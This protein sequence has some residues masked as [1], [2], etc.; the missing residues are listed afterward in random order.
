MLKCPVCQHALKACGHQL[1]CEHHHTYDQAKTGYYNLANKQG[2][3]NKEMVKARVAFLKKGYY[4]FL[5]QALMEQ[6]EG[7]WLDVGCGPGYYTKD[8]GIDLSKAAIQ[9]A[10][11]HHPGHF[12]V[13]NLA[14][15]PFMDE[16]FDGVLQVF[17]PF[18]A[19][20]SRRVLKPGGHLL[21]VGPAPRHL[22]EL[23]ERLYE[24]PYL[25]PVKHRQPEGF[26][27]VDEQLLEQRAWV[28]D[29]Q[30]LVGMTPYAYK[31]SLDALA[32]LA[33]CEKFECTFSFQL[34]RWE[35]L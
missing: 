17:V 27:L 30:E 15:L 35:K 13:G 25:N 20:E 8:W 3:D 21:V 28:E 7:L 6:M 4:R 33:D 9:Q 14:H 31:T 10:S 19:K 23:K 5:K 16:V 34:Q 12:V 32:K 1:V 2:G 18:E 22:W 24:K 26:K 29:V 11:K